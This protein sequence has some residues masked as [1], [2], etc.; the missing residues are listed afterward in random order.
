MLTPL[1][2]DRAL[3]ITLENVSRTQATRCVCLGARGKGST[4]IYSFRINI[5]IPPIGVYDI[6]IMI[7]TMD[8]KKALREDHNIRR[9][10][11]NL[12]LGF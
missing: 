6:A 2:D 5:D 1:A 10:Q 12:G 9:P 3:Q 7:P 8:I 4:L 11:F